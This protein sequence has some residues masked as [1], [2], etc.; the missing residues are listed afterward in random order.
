MSLC[1]PRPLALLLAVLLMSAMA[2]H[3][4]RAAEPRSE[5]A[6]VVGLLGYGGGIHQ[7]KNYILRGQSHY[8]IAALDS[9][10]RARLIVA[11]LARN[12]LFDAGERAS[13]QALDD[14]I[15][16]YQQALQKAANL[17]RESLS[18][19]LIDR[20]VLVEDD[21][22]LAGLERLRSRWVWSDFEE[23]EYRLGYGHAI[24][25][26][27]NFV[28]RGHQRHYTGALEQ[29]LAVESLIASQLATD[30]LAEEHRE[31]LGRLDRVVRGY[32]DYLP[33]IDKFHNM[34][35][36]VQQIDLAVKVNDGPGIEG[37]S[38]LRRPV[39]E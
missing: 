7:F 18:A 22:A 21:E 33:L 29:L 27:K 26:F 19:E 10:D 38:T 2:N 31:A 15:D 20:L 17:H 39:G 32:L 3:A 13:L 4:A 12:E 5:L 14:V 11:T 28:M 23:M 37:L 9:F 24:H 36:P 30:R 1:R 35:R 8:R 6:Q 34:Q 25:D 16:D